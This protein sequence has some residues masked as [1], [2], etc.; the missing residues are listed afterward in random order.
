MQETAEFTP[1]AGF[2]DEI[3]ETVTYALE[4]DTDALYLQATAGGGYRIDRGGSPP[5]GWSSAARFRWA[6]IAGGCSVR[7]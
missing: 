5:G 7:A 6:P 3:P 4:Y 2:D 1:A